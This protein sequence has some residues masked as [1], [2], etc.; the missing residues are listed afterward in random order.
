MDIV[1]PAL[2]K[3]EPW[4]YRVENTNPFLQSAAIASSCGHAICLRPRWPGLARHLAEMREH[5]DQSLRSQAVAITLLLLTG[6]RRG[7]IHSLQWSVLRGNW[8]KLR[9]SKTGPW[10]VWLGH[11]CIKC[12]ARFAHLDDAHLIDAVEEIGRAI[13]QAFAGGRQTC[14]AP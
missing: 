8:L 9:D 2:N 4:G 11:R 6:C 13:E 10:T 12:T 14:T 5:A 7:E 1:R 3:A